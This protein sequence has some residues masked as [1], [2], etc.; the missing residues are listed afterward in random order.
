[1]YKVCGKWWFIVWAE[2]SKRLREG[3]DAAD[4]GE[5]KK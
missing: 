5:Q 1:M 2:M 3:S 4:V